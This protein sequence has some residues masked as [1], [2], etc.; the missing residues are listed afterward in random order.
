MRPAGG[1]SLALAG[2]YE[3]W[4]DKAK[5]DDDPDAW[6]STYTIITTTVTD[7]VGRIHDRMPMAIA[8]AHWDDWLDPA[9]RPPTTCS[10]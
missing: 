5:P 9:I 8:K 6:V 2:L 1:E 4:R 10:R 7:E 3:F